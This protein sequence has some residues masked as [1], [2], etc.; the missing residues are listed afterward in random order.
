MVLD[1]DRLDF[2]EQCPVVPILTIQFDS[3]TSLRE[4][5]LPA[6]SLGECKCQEVVRRSVVRINCNRLPQWSLCS[7]H[8]LLSDEPFANRVQHPDIVGGKLVHL[9]QQ[10]VAFLPPSLRCHGMEQVEKTGERA[11]VEFQRAAESPL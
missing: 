7:F 1:Q 9:L 10:G 6:T 5:L 2:I 3:P 4:S 8:I 11:S